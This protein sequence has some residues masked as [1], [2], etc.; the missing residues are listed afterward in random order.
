MSLNAAEGLEHYFAA[1]VV[2]LL[3]L[4]VIG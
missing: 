3:E 2:K 4:S 1:I